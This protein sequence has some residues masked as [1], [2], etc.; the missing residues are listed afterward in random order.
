MESYNKKLRRFYNKKL[1]I[2]S[3]LKITPQYIWKETRV[4]YGCF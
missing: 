3:K 1:K 2:F 4:L